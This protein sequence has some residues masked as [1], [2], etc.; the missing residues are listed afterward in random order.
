MTSGGLASVS[1]LMYFGSISRQTFVFH[2]AVEW[3]NWV[4]PTIGG[5]PRWMV[6]IME[7]PMKNGWFGDSNIFGNTQLDKNWWIGNG[8]IGKTLK[9]WWNWKLIRASTKQKNGEFGNPKKHLGQKSSR[10]LHPVRLANFQ[11]QTIA[12]M[13]IRFVE[14]AD[15]FWPL[16][17][18]FFYHSEVYLRDIYTPQK[19]G[20]RAFRENLWPN[21]F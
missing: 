14:S 3:V 10:L 5:T 20:G 15:L 6:W 7:N 8:K 16:K 18:N 4:F 21:I 12:N 17:P 1:E 2:S 11:G 19:R 9:K 13:A